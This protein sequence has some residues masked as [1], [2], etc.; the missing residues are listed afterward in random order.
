LYPKRFSKKSR[1]P[2][3]DHGVRG[4]AGKRI[5]ASLLSLCVA[6]AVALPVASTWYEH[7]VET[8]PEL[9]VH[10]STAALL[11][12]LTLLTLL[13]LLLFWRRAVTLAGAAAR[14]ADQTARR[15]DDY[16]RIF[17]HAGDMM[18][19]SDHS[20]GLVL[21]ANGRACEVFNVSREKLLGRPLAS[22]TSSAQSIQAR[23]RRLSANGTQQGFDTIH[24]R[25]DGTRLHL[26]VVASP[27]DF[28]GRRSVLTV[29]RD[30]TERKQLEQQ[31]QHR[32]FHDSLT[33]LANRAL[34]RERAEHAFARCTRDPRM[35]VVMYFDLD[36]FKEVNDTL[37]HAAG[38]QL[39]IGVSRRVSGLLR[40]TDTVARL[41]GDEFAILI[42]DAEEW[43]DCVAVA[44]RILEVLRSPFLL[45]G[46]DVFVGSS[47]GIAS[48]TEASTFE[49]LLRHAD[50]AMY[51]AKS[52]GK[53]CFDIYQPQMH[54]SLMERAGC[55]ADL[56]TALERGE[57]ELHYQ[58]IVS[59]DDSRITGVEALLRWNHPRLGQ[60][61]P[62]TFIPLA[63]ETGLIGA[64][65]AWVLEEGCRQVREWQR[66]RPG[67]ADLSLTVNIAGRQ[68]HN[69]NL[70]GVV[71][72]ALERSAL[73]PGSLI[74]EATESVLMQHLD[75]TFHLLTE[76]EQLGVRVAIDDFG[77]GFSS[78]GFLARLPISLLK[79]DR[80]FVDGVHRGQEESALARA[81]IA[82]GETLGIATVAEGIRTREQ[83][84]ALHSLGCDYG[85]GFFFSA[86]VAASAVE[87]VLDRGDPA[88]AFGMTA[89]PESL[90]DPVPS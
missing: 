54:A 85:Q 10:L 12:S 59:L 14:Q 63:E 47:I 74:L 24:F 18:L 79:I 87:A 15:L 75:E 56:H 90:R 78:L 82:L 81:I 36:H 72:E 4:A 67:Y 22:I 23:F 55:E 68:F 2:A 16:L 28:H 27:I 76:L 17:R 11:L 71:T 29:H 9:V 31:L 8:Q 50:M 35:L 70:V 57:F 80:S 20:A 21:D 77:T 25:A 62:G 43:D 89:H 7:Q 53:G 65:G 60:M 84:T 64:L 52:R 61:E 38:D 32:V 48:S 3:G 19:V 13:L 40:A 51:S 46:K 6:A 83:L 45:D 86:P 44:E 41:G 49:E 34:F 39:L 42:E 1:G 37:G 26:E 69:A 88:W 73:S 58:P 5:P 30:V 66:A 33:G